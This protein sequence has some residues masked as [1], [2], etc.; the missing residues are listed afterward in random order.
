MSTVS[1]ITNYT[2]NSADSMDTLSGLTSQTLSQSDFLKLLVAQMTSQNPL[3]PQT[4]TQMAAQL[5]QFTALQQ[6]STM[7]ADLQILKAN[8]MLGGTVTLQVGVDTTTT[9]IVEAVRFVDG[10]P[11]IVVDGVSYDLSQ[12]LAISPTPV[13]QQ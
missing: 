12:V 5:A 13:A 7:A 2:T 8:S 1:S 4:D 11:Q 3:N 10:T 6:S 9:G